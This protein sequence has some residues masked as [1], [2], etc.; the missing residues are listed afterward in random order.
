MLALNNQTL[1][2]F[3]L[4][5]VPGGVTSSSLPYMT[6]VRTSDSLGVVR[7]PYGLNHSPWV[8]NLPYPPDVD[9]ERHEHLYLVLALIIMHTWKVDYT[10]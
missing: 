7:V 6:D 9:N 1:T 2:W 4:R 8:E 3:I 5:R 10:S